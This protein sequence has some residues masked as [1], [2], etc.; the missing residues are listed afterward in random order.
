MATACVA[1]AWVFLAAPAP[2]QDVPAELERLTGS[3]TS[4][5]TPEEAQAIIGSA[6]DATVAEM[7]FLKRPFARRKLQNIAVA[8]SALD[9]AAEGTR[10]SVTCDERPPVVDELDGGTTD[11]RTEGETFQAAHAWDDGRLVQ[12]IGN[13]DGVRRNVYDL[14][15]DG[16]TLTLQ[17]SISSD[18]LPK[19][20]TW[21]REFRRAAGGGA[22][23]TVAP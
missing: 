8:C 9:I 5:A 12:A 16:N 22:P 7:F 4:A 14:S 3:W 20:V 18:R 11:Y 13:R 10:V 21:T 17:V 19:A 1:A 15:E 6:I 23:T 2:A